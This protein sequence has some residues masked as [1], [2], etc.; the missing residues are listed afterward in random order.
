MA[1]A[2]DRLPVGARAIGLGGF[3]RNDLG[4]VH[5]ED[6]FSVEKFIASARSVNPHVEIMQVS[7]W[8]GEGLPAWYAWIEERVR[9]NGELRREEAR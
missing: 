6:P 4:G 3:V 2:S 9:R 8:R 7:A 5:L 1:W